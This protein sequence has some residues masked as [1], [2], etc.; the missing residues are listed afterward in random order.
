VK[1]PRKYGTFVKGG[2]GKG[3]H[4]GTRRFYVKEEKKHILVVLCD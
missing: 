3:R 1:K 4:L 2:G